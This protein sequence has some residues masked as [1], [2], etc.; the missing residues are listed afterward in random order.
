MVTY[1]QVADLGSDCFDD[2]GDLV[3]EN[4][5]QRDTEIMRRE[6]EVRVT[7]AG[8]LDSDLTRSTAQRN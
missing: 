5:V 7:Q 8:R 4:S 1:G 6:V 2:A 3:A